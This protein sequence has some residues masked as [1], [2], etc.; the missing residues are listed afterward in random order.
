QGTIVAPNA[1]INLATVQGA[2]H[3]GS[4]F[5]KDIEV[6][7]DNKITLKPFAWDSVL[8]TGALRV[9]GRVSAAFGTQRIA[10]PGALTELQVKVATSCGGVSYRMVTQATT[11]ANGFFGVALPSAA[12]G[13]LRLCT[14]AAGFTGSCQDVNPA[15]PSQTLVEIT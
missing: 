15:A 9:T 11:D 14:S 13:A 6:F 12:S 8:P 2:G 5:A 7:P 3:Q 1:R 4:F 10:V